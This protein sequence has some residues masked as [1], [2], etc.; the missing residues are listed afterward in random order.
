MRAPR[1]ASR[2]SCV[3]AREGDLAPCHRGHVRWTDFATL[4]VELEP[5]MWMEPPED[6]ELPAPEQRFASNGLEKQTAF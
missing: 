4:T 2:F 1:P 3:E 5:I 6:V